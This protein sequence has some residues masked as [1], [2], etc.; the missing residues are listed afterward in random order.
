MSR[1]R[2]T[3]QGGDQDEPKGKMVDIPGPSQPEIDLRDKGKTTGREDP[4]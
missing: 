1:D 3:Q 2:D 4:K